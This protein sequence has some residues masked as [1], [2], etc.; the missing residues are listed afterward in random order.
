MMIP[1][2]LRRRAR[3]LIMDTT[4][5][6]LLASIS[7][8]DW[9]LVPGCDVL[10]SDVVFEEATRDP[11]PD[12]DSRKESR[13]HIQS[14][15]SANRHRLSVLPTAEGE[16]YRREMELWRRAG[17]PPDLKPDWSDRG[18]RSLLAAI[19]TLK[20]AL[21]QGEEI[22]VIVDDRDARDA[23]SAVRADIMMIGTRTFIRWMAED[24]HIA[25]AETAWQAIRIATDNKADPG[26][27][28][29]P[30][31]IRPPR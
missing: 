16:N 14:W 29:D 17:M 26:S 28:P 15:Y 8:L 22:I 4:P 5:L 24:Y 6:S 21:E 12:R 18:E 10:I 11:G 20:S 13:N 30:V 2:E 7:A 19:K 25:A 9:L 27:D 3:F 1:A 31:F 23:I